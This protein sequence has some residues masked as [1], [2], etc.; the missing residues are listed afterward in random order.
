MQK[1][2]QG[3]SVCSLILV[4]CLFIRCVLPLNDYVVQDYVESV[5]MTWVR[6]SW[7]PPLSW[8]GFHSP[9]SIRNSAVSTITWNIQSKHLYIIT[10]PMTSFALFLLYYLICLRF[11]N[12]SPSHSLSMRRMSNPF[13]SSRSD[14]WT[15]VPIWQKPILAIACSLIFE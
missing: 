6:L 10:P 9:C 11:C 12:H 14:H 1:W 13:K 4:F 3:G 7:T 5:Y 15:C 2:L 8:S